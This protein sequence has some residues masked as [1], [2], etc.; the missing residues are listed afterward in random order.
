MKAPILPKPYPY[1]TTPWASPGCAPVKVRTLRVLLRL[2]SGDPGRA[3]AM[4]ALCLCQAP[5]LF[6]LT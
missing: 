5:V 6:F 1:Q 2:G 4:R 3:A